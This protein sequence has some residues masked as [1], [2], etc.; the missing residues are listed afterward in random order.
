MKKRYSIILTTIAIG[1]IAFLLTPALWAFPTDMTPPETLFPFFLLQSLIEALGFGAAVA[2]LFFVGIPLVQRVNPAHKLKA[3][4]MV[5]CF[6][7]V[8][9][10]WWPH[11]NFHKVI[12]LDFAGLLILEYAFHVSSVVA[13]ALALWCFSA[14]SKAKQI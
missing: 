1:V 5:L 13:I 14:L 6:V 4:V 7:W 2:Y 12:G 11:T 9:G 3:V 8:M 10:S